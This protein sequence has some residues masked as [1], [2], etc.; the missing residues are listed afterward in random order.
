MGK[1]TKAGATALLLIFAAGAL[2]RLSTAMPAAAVIR[3]LAGIR[4]ALALYRQEYKTYPGSFER[5]LSE[6]KLE[7]VP[8]LKLAWHRGSSKVKDVP[9]FAIKDTG[10]WNYVSDPASAQFGLVYIDCR[11]KDEQ[12]RFWSEF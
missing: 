6:A 5:V 10:A 12:G 9:A 11:H 2:M 1:R 4:V 8:G 7:V 3:K